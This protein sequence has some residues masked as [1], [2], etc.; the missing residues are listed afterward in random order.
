MHKAKPSE[1]VPEPLPKTDPRFLVAAEVGN[2][3]GE[4]TFN[5]LT[6]SQLVDYCYQG[7]Y[8]SC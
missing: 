6:R 3:E 5:G 8:I 1:D 2:K 4:V 7:E